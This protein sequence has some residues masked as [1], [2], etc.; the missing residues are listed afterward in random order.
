MHRPVVPIRI[1]TNPGRSMLPLEISQK[2]PHAGADGHARRPSQARHSRCQVS[3]DLLN[4]QIA[5]RFYMGT[6]TKPTQKLPRL[7]VV[8]DDCSL[9]NP[10]TSTIQWMYLSTTSVWNRSFSLAGS[11]GGGQSGSIIRMKRRIGAVCRIRHSLLLF[12]GPP[13][14]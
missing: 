14:R 3:I 9:A 10:W 7:I 6:I 1:E 2:T 12:G 11:F 4:A 8:L 5:E 13:F